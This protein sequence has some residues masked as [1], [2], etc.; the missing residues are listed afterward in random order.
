MKWLNPIHVEIKM[1]PETETEITSRLCTDSSD[2][3]SDD[4]GDSE[5]IPVKGAGIP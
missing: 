3:S 4:S 1:G 5:I 2:D